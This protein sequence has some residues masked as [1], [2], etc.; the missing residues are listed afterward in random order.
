MRW[1]LALLPLVPGCPMCEWD[2]ELDVVKGSSVLRPGERVTLELDSEGYVAGPKHCRGHWYV[3]D[4]EGGSA[5][6]GTISRCG[7]FWATT[8]PRPRPY[9]VLVTGAQH[10][11]DCCVDCCAIE[12]IEL[13]IVD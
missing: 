13:T 7:V 6:I 3:N 5:E 4:F 2:H 12:N 8:W 10:C 9:K 1:L 11:L